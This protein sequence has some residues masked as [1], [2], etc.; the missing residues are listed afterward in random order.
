MK[1]KDTAPSVSDNSSLNLN[2]NSSFGSQMDG[3]FF[4]DR[5]FGADSN[6]SPAKSYSVFYSFSQQGFDKTLKLF[7]LP[8][9][10]STSGKQPLI[11]TVFYKYN[12]SDAI[13]TS[14]LS[15]SVQDLF[16]FQFSPTSVGLL[17]YESAL[18][19]PLIIKTSNGPCSKTLTIALLDANKNT[20]TGQLE[21]LRN[22][23]CFKNMGF[24]L[25]AK[26]ISDSSQWFFDIIGV[27]YNNNSN[28][29][30]DNNQ[31]AG[32]LLYFGMVTNDLD[33]TT[34]SKR[35]NLL[36]LGIPEI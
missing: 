31:V 28:V 22:V 20:P 29:K 30:N 11:F 12:V 7:D 23:N 14:G 36:Y 15:V 34:E 18:W 8:N 4:R 32:S 27:D 16:K 3:K 25:I 21:Y 17:N 9:C 35:P 13:S 1:R 26:S 33:R 10:Q 24:G 2:T 5:C 19:K 6:T